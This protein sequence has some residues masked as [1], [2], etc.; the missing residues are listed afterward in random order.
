[1]NNAFTITPIYLQA[2]SAPLLD[3]RLYLLRHKRRARCQTSP[4]G[5]KNG[6][7]CRQSLSRAA[8]QAGHSMQLHSS[9]DLSR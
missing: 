3:L 4:P 1:M 9:L 6:V 7:L 5:D 8:F 2:Q